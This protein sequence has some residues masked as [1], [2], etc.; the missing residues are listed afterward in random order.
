VKTKQS[1]KNRDKFSSIDSKELVGR[2]DSLVVKA[3]HRP[4]KYTEY[5]PE[6]FD[7]QQLAMEG[8]ANV[9]ENV[10]SSRDRTPR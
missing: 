8:I 9:L 1:D 4:R 10:S 6:M 5:F 7:V 3:A 2:E